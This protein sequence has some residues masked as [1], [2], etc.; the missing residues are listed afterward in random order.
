MAKTEKTVHYK[1]VSRGAWRLACSWWWYSIADHNFVT[2]NVVDVTCG[3]CKR[4]RKFK[5]AKTEL[6]VE[7]LCTSIAANREKI[8]K[9]FIAETG[10]KPSECEQ[11]FVHRPDGH[12]WFVRKRAEQEPDEPVLLTC[13]G[14]GNCKRIEFDSDSMPRGT[15]KIVS[16]CEECSNCEK[17]ESER[18]FATDGA[19]LF[20]SEADPVCETCGGNGV[21]CKKCSTRVRPSDFSTPA[22]YCPF[23]RRVAD[24]KPC[25]DCQPKP[26]SEGESEKRL[27][28]QQKRGYYID[29]DAAKDAATVKPDEA[30]PAEPGESSEL[31]GLTVSTL[32][33]RIEQLEAENKQL[34]VNLEKAKG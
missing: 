30:K 14:C 18:Y 12:S 25:P 6:H 24:V 28:C 11:V 33:S 9:A 21:L 20:A 5:E 34:K 8:L 13:S 27:N 7:D 2:K 31:T 22:F 15:A 3:N 17:G 10:L 1:Y 23:C 19:E 16:L 29:G 32:K 26:E 4:T